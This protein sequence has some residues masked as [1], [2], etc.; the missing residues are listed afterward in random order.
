MLLI[1]LHTPIKL[2]GRDGAKQMSNV[3]YFFFRQEFWIQF[4]DEFQKYGSEINKAS[5]FVKKT[6]FYPDGAPIQ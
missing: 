6:Q 5:N 4:D 3:V 1:F 2:S